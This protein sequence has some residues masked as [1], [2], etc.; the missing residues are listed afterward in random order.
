MKW[1]KG[2]KMYKFPVICIGNGNVVYSI[3]TVVNTI[4][5]TKKKK[6]WVNDPALP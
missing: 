3:V 2:L 6:K 1:T 4:L 5:P